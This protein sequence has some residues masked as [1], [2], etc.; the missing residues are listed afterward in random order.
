MPEDL[1]SES[2]QLR[3][4]SRE[5]RKSNQRLLEHMDRLLDDANFAILDVERAGQIPSNSGA[6]DGGDAA[7]KITS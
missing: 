7:S 3:A 5:L 4:A 2:A 6:Q 1:L